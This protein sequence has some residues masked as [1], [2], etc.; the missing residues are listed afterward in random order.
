MDRKLFLLIKCQK[1]DYYTRQTKIYRSP[2]KIHTEK[3]FA[4][5][6][7]AAILPAR[8][9]GNSDQRE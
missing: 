3:T 7:A 5:A 2:C 9:Y 4:P 1:W 6:A 8:M